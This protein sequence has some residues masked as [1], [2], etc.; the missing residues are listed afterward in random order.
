M[1]ERQRTQEN[2]FFLTLEGP[3]G[4][5]KTTQIP[6]IAAHLRR[7]GYAVLVAREPGGTRLGEE[8]RSLLKAPPG[9]HRICDRSEMLLFSASRAQLMDEVILPH[10]EQGGAVL[11]DRFADSTTVYQG[12][13]RGLDLEL[14]GRVHEFALRGRWPDLTLVLDLEPELGFARRHTETGGR[15][16]DRI[17]AEPLA[18]H[19]RVRDGFLR[20]AQAAP[21]RIRVVDAAQSAADV[22]AQ[23]REV[24]DRALA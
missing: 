5:G 7:R 12:Y 22:H 1:A 23:I 18:F 16:T 9:T 3:E 21:D 10:L 20:L 6:L 4:A 24:I 2:G 19:R 15:D 11:C 8:L 17:E 14:I 13:A